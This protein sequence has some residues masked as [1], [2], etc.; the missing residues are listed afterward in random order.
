MTNSED[1]DLTAALE[2]VLS[3]SA[4]FN[5]KLKNITGMYIIGIIKVK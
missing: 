5:R 4:L 2:A 1:P 3:G